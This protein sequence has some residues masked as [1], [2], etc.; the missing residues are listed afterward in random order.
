MA[1]KKELAP[2]L[3]EEI[4]ERL[5]FRFAENMHRHEG[6][7]WDKIQSKL[8]TAS[9]KLWSLNE[10]EISG[11]E[12]DIVE[13]NDTPG[14]Y[15]FVDCSPESPKGRRSLCYDREALESRKNILL[16]VL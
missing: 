15:T 10:M 4:I 8:E 3:Q 12:P 14:I 9:D 16:K 13:L 11:G 5:K 6:F 7:D 1:I 2:E